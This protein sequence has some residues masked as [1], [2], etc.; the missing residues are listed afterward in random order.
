MLL[1]TRG[2]VPGK[3]GVTMRLIACVVLLLSTFAFAAEDVYFKKVNYI[4]Q[5][6]EERKEKDARLIFASDKLLITHEDDPA[7]GTFAEI[8][9]ASISKVVYEKS[10][11][12]RW[13]T[14]VFLTPWALFSKGKKHWLTIQYSKP[15]N[16]EDFV[17]LKLD[18]K[19][20]QMIIATMEAKTGKE[21]E[22]L[23][24]D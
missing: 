18:K 15:D 23:L 2:N 9:K 5:E 1:P 17:L 7:K 20:Y 12:P 19:N 8:S 24:E 4:Y 10:S 22:K 21:I 3:K 14:V 6:S 13:K 11:H 16:T